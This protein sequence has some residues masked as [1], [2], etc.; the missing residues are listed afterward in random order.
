MKGCYIEQL[1]TCFIVFNKSGSLLSLNTLYKFCRFKNFNFD[2]LESS[3]LSELKNENT[4]FIFFIRNPYERFLTSFWR[5]FL[6]KNF[7]ANIPND[8]YLVS[9][10]ELIN[11]E[12]EYF[13]DNYYAII[14]D[15]NDYHI[16]PQKYQLLNASCKNEISISTKNIESLYGKNY[17]FLKIEEFHKCLKYI[18]ESRSPYEYINNPKYTIIPNIEYF[19]DWELNDLFLLSDL[20]FGTR[21]Q[22]E[23]QH[24][25][26][27]KNVI[28]NDI[29]FQKINEIID[30]EMV[31]YGY[32][33]NLI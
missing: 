8:E 6:E 3:N 11:N 32:K 2:S 29:Q 4:K 5:W 16:A 30:D 31:F 26:I 9:V 17:T 23:K 33:K 22:L 20:Y 12:L 28:V 13:I 25:H 14:K 24:H 19:V 21:N 18:S 1:N 27:N 15:K 7:Y 10:Q